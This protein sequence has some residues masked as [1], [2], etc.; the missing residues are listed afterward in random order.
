MTIL[1]L[2]ALSANTNPIPVPVPP[3]VTDNLPQGLVVPMPTLPLPSITIL[4]FDVIEEEDA[5]ANRLFVT[6]YP[7]DHTPLVAPP[8]NPCTD[9]VELYK[10]SKLLGVVV[11]TPKLPSAVRRTFSL[12]STANA[13]YEFAASAPMSAW[14]VAPPSALLVSM[15][16]SAPVS[17]SVRRKT[18]LLAC[19]ARSIAVSVVPSKVRSA[20]EVIAEAL[21]Q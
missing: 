3:P 21:D 19:T 11:P 16:K 20:S 13:R 10:V 17:E 4:T 15:R 1:G 8:E 12:L 14:M 7:I 9:A 5:M 6:S 18:G 2:F